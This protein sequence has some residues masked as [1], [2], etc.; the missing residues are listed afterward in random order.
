[1]LTGRPTQLVLFLTIV[2]TQLINYFSLEIL[3]LANLIDLI[4]SIF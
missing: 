4:N 2:W 1:M 3:F